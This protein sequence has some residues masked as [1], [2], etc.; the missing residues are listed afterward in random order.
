[1]MMGRCG[2]ATI[3]TFE[4]LF[5]TEI[6]VEPGSVLYYIDDSGPLAQLVRAADS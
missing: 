3:R 2:R 4:R 1:M 5:G 6:L